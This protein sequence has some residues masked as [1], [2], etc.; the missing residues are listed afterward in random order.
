[1]L[2]WKVSTDGDAVT[3]LPRRQVSAVPQ[4]AAVVHEV[5]N[6]GISV[7]PAAG[8]QWPGR[9]TTVT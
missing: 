6:L 2:R 9:G 1:M 4:S 3:L 7:L 8:T 5:L